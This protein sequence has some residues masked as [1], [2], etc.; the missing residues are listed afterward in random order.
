[1]ARKQPKLEHVKYVHSKG[2]LYA[3]FNTGQ[4]RDGKPIYARLPHP[5]VPGF[6]D[7][8]ASLLGGRTKRQATTYTVADM[9]EDFR[10]SSHLADLAENTQKLYR[11]QLARIVDC[12]GEYPVNDMDPTEVGVV[13]ETAD[14]KPGTH[15]ACMAVLAVL[16][17]W[18]RRARKTT[19]E[20]T[21]DIDRREGGAHEPWP[22]GVLEAALTAKDDTVRLATHLLYFTGLRIGDACS[23]HWTDIHGG[24][25]YITPQKTRRFKKHLQIQIH[26]ELQVELDRT[27][28][29]HLNILGGIE[30]KDLRKA[31]QAFTRSVGVETVPHGLR[32]NAVIA[33]L[34]AGCTVPE[35]AA[36][37]GQTFQVVEHYAAKVNT[38]KLGK[39]AM[40][41]F[42]N[43]RAKSGGTKDA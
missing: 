4:K 23:L 35:A 15:N 30:S 6:H 39:T 28:R 1:M 13:L 43:K 27:P 40:L 19:A 3:Y 10:R 36:I 5:S 38:R 24:A 34:E 31:L 33:L 7:S 22:E 25:I 37:T 42:E 20:P 2:R 32:K 16:F 17:K 21:K 12:W 29:Q 9:A 18:G 8:Y 11:S 14:W 41:K 26:A